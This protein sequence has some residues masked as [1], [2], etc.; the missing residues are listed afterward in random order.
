MTWDQVPGRRQAEHETAPP[1]IGGQQQFREELTRLRTGLGVSLAQLEQ[2]SQRQGKRLPPATVS[3]VL[4]RDRLPEW[5]FVADFLAACGLDEARR[6][7]WQQAWRELAAVSAT[8]VSVPAPAAAPAPVAAAAAAPA[9]AGAG[10]P[11]GPEAAAASPPPAPSP[12]PVPSPPAAAPSGKPPGKSPDDIPPAGGRRWRAWR[13]RLAGH[14]AAVA[15]CAALALAAAAGVYAVD[16]HNKSERQEQRRR[17]EQQRQDKYR[18]EHCGTVNPALVTQA[19]GE[20]TGVTD[21]LD[22]SDVFGSA[23][24]PVLTA[25]GAENHRATRDGHYVTVAFLAPLTSVGSAGKA[26]DLTLDQFVGEVEGAYTA[27]ERANADDGPLK[28]RLVLANM[29]SGELHWKRAVDTLTGLAAADNLV[30]VTGMGL[31]QQE[32]VDAARTLGAQDIPMVADLITADG[33]DTTGIIDSAKNAP[34]RINGLVRVTLTN[35][36]Q[37]GALGE[38]LDGDTRTAALVRTAKTPNGT[39]DFYTDS[40]YE[41][42]RTVGGLKKHLDPAADDFIFD[43]RGGVAS[44]LD[45][46]GQNLCSTG[47]PVDTVYFAAR[48]KYLPD[49]LQALSRRSCHRRPITVVSGSDTAALDPK[50]LAALNQDGEAPIT[51][52]YASLPTAA[53]LRAPGNSDHNL[54]EQFLDAFGGDHHGQKFPAAHAT[55]GYWPVLAHDAVLTAVTAIRNAT[56]P[57]TA[58]PNRYAV[59]NHLYALADGAVPAATGRFGIDPTGN[60]TKVPITIHRLGATA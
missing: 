13:A 1:R 54:Y 17:Q 47:R 33:F 59:L 29:G 26:K 42:F 55:R 60:R 16:E 32:S 25:I 31:S 5:E 52:L 53:Q 24:E 37:L 30:A 41:D 57:T 11:G 2:A 3:N 12:P 28:I 36:A 39:D 43:P 19:G 49:F 35:A 46:I 22:R 23:L 44:I 51:V 58:R 10:A 45:A 56:T 15:V 48:E 20:C 18:K 27:V 21:G 14:R 38:E 8:Q 34:K 9:A 4:S 6:G 50:T 40:L 7:P